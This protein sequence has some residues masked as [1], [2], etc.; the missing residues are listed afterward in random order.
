MAEET[1]F[2]SGDHVSWRTSQGEITGKVRR[3]L[4]APMTSKGHYV[5]ASEEHP[6]YLV[7][8]DESGEEA[9]HKPGALTKIT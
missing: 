9:A 4:T 2:K 1:S 3:K 8:S 5:A 7:V 6:E